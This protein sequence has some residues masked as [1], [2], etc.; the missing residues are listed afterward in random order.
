MTSDADLNDSGTLTQPK[1]RR[2]GEVTI[3]RTR[4]RPAEHH[5]AQGTWSKEAILRALRDWRRLTGQPPRIYEW[6][7]TTARALGAYNARCRVWEQQ[8]PRWPSSTTVCAHFSTWAAALAAAGMKVPSRR[9]PGTLRERVDTA[10]RLYAAGLLQAEIAELLEV[11]RSTVSTYLSAQRC[12]C[13]EPAIRSR[14]TPPLCR[15]CARTRRAPAWDRDNVMAAYREW[16]AQT[17]RRPTQTEWSPHLLAR[18]AKWHREFPRWPTIAEVDTV[19]GRWG[20]LVE[21]AGDGRWH[22]E[23]KWTREQALAAVESLADALGRTPR[24]IDLNG[25]GAPSVDSIRTLFGSWEAALHELGRHPNQT[26]HTPEALITAIRDADG[27][28]GRSPRPGEIGRHLAKAI[29]RHFGSWEAGLQATGI[30]PQPRRRW[31]DKEILTLLRTWANEHGRLPLA[32]DWRDGDPRAARPSARIVQH[33]FGS[34]HTALEAAGLAEP[35]P[36]WT[37]EEVLAALEKLADALGRTPRTA[38]LEASSGPSA[39]RVRKL[40]GSWEAALRELGHEPNVT[41]RPTRELLAAVRTAHQTLGRSPN[42]IDVDHRIVK[43]VRRRFGSWNSCLLAAG[44]PPP[45][46]RDSP[47]ERVIVALQAWA[48]QHG[49]PPRTRDWLRADPD[50]RYPVAQV[51]QRRFGTW[52]TALEAAGLLGDSS[53]THAHT[54]SA[55]QT[56]A[57]PI[58]EHS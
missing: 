21:A 51:V 16:K 43:A 37:R 53:A 26:T 42:P 40:F 39:T 28:L 38:D 8:H 50:R 27:S 1:P 3:A 20:A 57:P 2:R 32:K 5:T 34:W 46:P 23:P 31:T 6:S 13:G 30:E 36:R 55:T 58:A 35:E 22:R 24:T 4:W 7:P 11:Q 54:D 12:A 56:P 14:S 29:R 45:P 18:S 33:R 41:S 15:Q 25:S 48:T 9:P 44:I 10:R 19:F 47:T 52:R 17:G 49:R